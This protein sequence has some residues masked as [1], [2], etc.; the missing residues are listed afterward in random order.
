LSQKL[1]N[2][3]LEKRTYNVGDWLSAKIYSDMKNGCTKCQCNEWT[4]IPIRGLKDYK[5]PVCSKC[6]EDPSL[7]VIVATVKDENGF[8]KRIRIRHN[9]KGNRLKNYVDVTKTLQDVLEEI[10]NETFD[11]RRY[12]S[13]E[14]RESYL[15]ENIIT[16]YLEHH[17]R[18]LKRGELTPGGLKDK[19]TLIK[20]HLLKEN[21]GFSG[22][23]IANITDKKIR[24]FYNSYTS[25]LRM[26]DKATS[27][28]KTILYYAMD[29]LRKIKSLPRFP[30]ISAADMVSPDRFLSEE[31]Q[32]LVIS[33]IENPLYQAAI[34]TLALYALRPCEV[35]SLKWKDI[36]FQSNIFYI[37]S[38]ISLN[39][40]IPGRKSQKS[41]AHPLP[42]VDEFLNILNGIPRSINENDY[43]FKGKKGKAIG[44]NV[45]TRAWNEACKL[46]RVK[47]V[48]LYQ[49]TKHSTLSNLGRT[50]SDS[51][52]RK[53]TGHT[54]S[55]IIQRYS[56]SNLDDIRALI[57]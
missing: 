44:G 53:L 39:S 4:S 47:G 9:Q 12:E 14:S 17:E 10:E 37:Q 51:Q 34:K 40:E 3:H 56:Q 21:V 2:A 24:D 52:L 55:K 48:T 41:K 46:A 27:E 1:V 50:A 43:I 19:K 5:A 32:A 6:G 30:E 13:L 49:G 38:H 22:L 26:R 20:N 7:Y 33:K 57:K 16:D 15:F 25:S 54:N 18:C 35:R 8:K 28:L 36:N 11:V 23:D 45:L 42:L 29:E 31:K